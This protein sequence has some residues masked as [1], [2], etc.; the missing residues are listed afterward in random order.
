MNAESV[1]SIWDDFEKACCRDLTPDGVETVK[2][3]FYAGF[4]ASL[5]C[6]AA[7]PHRFAG[8]APKILQYL[9]DM[10]IETNEHFKGVKNGEH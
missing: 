10:I 5:V 7:A 8:D 4:E 9:K 2:H 6:V 1:K 3:A